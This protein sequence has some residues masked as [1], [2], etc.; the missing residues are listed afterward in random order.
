MLGG[1]RKQMR[2]CDHVKR[3]TPG[4]G[5]QR[6]LGT[7]I[8]CPAA[9]VACLD[10]G[11]VRREHLL[12]M[13]AKKVETSRENASDTGRAA[14]LRLELPCKRAR[15]PSHAHGAVWPAQAEMRSTQDLF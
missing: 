8:M 3:S 12:G 7:A 14:R 2:C 10:K 4:L 15:Q 9:E 1:K 13:M 5:K 6:H 11:E